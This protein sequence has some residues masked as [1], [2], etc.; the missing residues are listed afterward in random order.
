MRQLLQ[1]AESRR[2]IIPILGDAAR[3]ESYSRLVESV[4]LV[5]QDV[6]QRNQAEIATLNSARYLKT[7]GTLVLMIKTRSIDST[8]PPG[9]I[10]G[11][12]IGM[13]KGLEVLFVTDLL[14]YHHDH[15][16]VVA[17]KV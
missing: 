8:A 14:P 15:W 13:L 9:E 7:G 5:Y 10:R 12:E 2:N 11:S 16:A 6:A 17:K 3:P 1:L 4:D